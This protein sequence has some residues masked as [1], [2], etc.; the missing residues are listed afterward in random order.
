MLKQSTLLVML[1]ALTGCAIAQKTY[2]PDGREGYTITCGGALDWS[3]CERKAGEICRARGYE[4]L[5]RTEETDHLNHNNDNRTLLIA[6][7]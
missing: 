7:H 1:A 2:T 5:N 3:Y 4:V 6:C